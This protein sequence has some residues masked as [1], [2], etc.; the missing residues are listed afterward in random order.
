M[1]NAHSNEKKHTHTFGDLT[2][3][4]SNE[5]ERNTKDDLPAKK[6]IPIAKK[7]AHT[8]NPRDYVLNK[9]VQKHGMYNKN[10]KGIIGMELDV[11]VVGS[12]LLDHRAGSI[13]IRGNRMERPG[14][15]SYNRDSFGIDQQ[16]ELGKR[17]YF[18][19]ETIPET[20]PRD[21]Q[22]ELFA[23]HEVNGP[24]IS[25]LKINDTV[26]DGRVK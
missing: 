9:S 25:E 3:N 2:P 15:S 13:P 5:S 8:M 6:A 18:M 17:Q 21:T 4:D 24:K 10:A 19:P 23:E 20:L 22:M 7:A 16:L 1:G 26:M 12:P 11:P 14:A